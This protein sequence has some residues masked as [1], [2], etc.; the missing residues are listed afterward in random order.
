V[1]LRGSAKE[2]PLSFTVGDHQEPAK[3]ASATSWRVVTQVA[4][5]GIFFI[6]A[7]TALE[8]ARG[9]LLPVLA[10]FVI[11]AMLTPMMVHAEQY[12]VPPALTALVLVLLV[13][14]IFNGVLLLVSAPVVEWIGQAPQIAQSIKE[15]LY[16]FDGPITALQNLRDAILPRGANDGAGLRIDLKDLVQPVF[17]VL[18]PAIGSLVV[19]FGTLF[20]Y[21]FGRNDVRRVLVALLE[22][23]NARLIA[24]RIL[25]D[26]EHNLVTYLTL[27]SGINLAVGVIA[28]GIA[29]LAGLPS[30]ITW[31][32]VAFLLNYVPYLGP[33]IVELAMFCVGLITFPTLT[34]AFIAPAAFV[35][36]TTIE[37]HF[38]TP[39]IVGH[40][41]TVNPL[42]VFLALVFW[43]WLWGPMGAFLAMPILIVTLVIMSHVFPSDEPAL[44]E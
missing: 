20:F 40:R 37:G 5:I 33:L 32:V 10:A 17:A 26:V 9:V 44:P 22:K 30:P 3:V 38:V 7:V 41:L 34:Q 1:E 14:A 28:A 23:R 36:F 16:V 18:T 11:G 31:G 8:L 24:L 39:S 29:W 13:I 43:T 19:F 25:N 21:L 27:V 6:L 12:R 15:K 2:R 42:M 4:T 35:V